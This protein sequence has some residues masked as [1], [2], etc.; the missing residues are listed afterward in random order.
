MEPQYASSGVLL[1]G[2][3]ETR[4][5]SLF[6]AMQT[7]GKIADFARATTDQEFSAKMYKKYDIE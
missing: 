7:D 3:C 4:L 6:N 1:C 5:A 2:A